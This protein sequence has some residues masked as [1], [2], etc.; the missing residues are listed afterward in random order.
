V[1]TKKGYVK[2]EIKK[3]KKQ[4]I[5]FNK[6]ET[7]KLKELEFEFSQKCVNPNCRNYC[8]FIKTVR[9]QC[10]ECWSNYNQSYTVEHWCE[11]CMS[12]EVLGLGR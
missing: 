7:E 12:R 6:K 11:L 4:K 5:A 8:D 1:I 2:E 3:L 9:N 10:C